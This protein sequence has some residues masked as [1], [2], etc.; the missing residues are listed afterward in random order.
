MTLKQYPFR[1]EIV[2]K[3]LDI[4]SAIGAFTFISALNGCWE[5]ERLEKY[6]RFHFHTCSEVR[7]RWEPEALTQWWLPSYL[8]A[9]PLAQGMRLVMER[10]QKTE[11]LMFH[12]PKKE[13]RSYVPKLNQSDD[14]PL[15]GQ[16]KMGVGSPLKQ[17]C[18]LFNQREVCGMCAMVVVGNPVWVVVTT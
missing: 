8:F 5:P 4:Y 13:T 16:L 6:W 10:L 3:L 7:G 2:N 15:S 1:I 12:Q 9:S 17:L 18:K 14:C 11:T